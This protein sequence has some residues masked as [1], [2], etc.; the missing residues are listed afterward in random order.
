MINSFSGESRMNLFRPV[1][2]E[3]T[4]LEEQKLD[5][6]GRLTKVYL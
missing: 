1:V 3:V 2:D 4:I 5:L 6:E